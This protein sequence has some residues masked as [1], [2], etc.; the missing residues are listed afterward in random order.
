MSNADTKHLVE[1]AVADIQKLV[2]AL[3]GLKLV[4]ELELRGRGDVQLYRVELGG[5]GQVRITKDI[6]SDAKVRVS[7]PRSHFNELVEHPGLR[8]WREAFE[9]G[10]ARAI[11][12]PQTL[13]LIEQVA[14]KQEERDR[15]KRARGQGRRL[16][17]S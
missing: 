3:A 4:A 17:A 14:R 5:R 8:F 15:S 12:P 10:H 9:S 13:K 2:P 7:I 16:T 11:G 6:A 1:K